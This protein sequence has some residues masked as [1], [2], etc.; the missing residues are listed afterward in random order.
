MIKT[1]LALLHEENEKVED[2]KVLMQEGLEM[3]Y[4]L[5]ETIKTL[6]KS[7]ST[8]VISFLNRHEEDFPNTKFPR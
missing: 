3:C 4:R 8:D 7:R 5:E 6:G 2:A 1:S